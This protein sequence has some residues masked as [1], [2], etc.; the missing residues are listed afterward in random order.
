M[1]YVTE[2]ISARLNTVE[3]SEAACCWCIIQ[4][5]YYERLH[6]AAEHVMDEL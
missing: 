3:V 1:P 4:L 2:I 5:I 6:H